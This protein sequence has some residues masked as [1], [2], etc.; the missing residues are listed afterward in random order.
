MGGSAAAERIGGEFLMANDYL[1]TDTELTSIADA[2]R[3]K[4][5]TSAALI[6]PVDFVTAI[7]AI[8]TGGGSVT[9]DQDGYIVLP[10][11]GSGGGGG[12]TGLVFE[13]GIYTP[14]ADEQTPT[15]TF[16][17]AHT[18]LPFFVGIF[19]MTETAVPSTGLIQWVLLNYN[20]LFNGTITY[21]STTLYGLKPFCT[22]IGSNMSAT[23]SQITSLTGNETAS[24]SYYLTT[25]G[26]TPNLTGTRY[27][28]ANRNYK[29]IAAWAP[30]T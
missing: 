9:Q 19:D 27:F 12:G 28:L 29:W 4:G 15:F 30:T 5:G 2:I 11:T 23:S 26:I 1:T 24:M 20:A 21:G 7:N 16:T 8:T 18:S 17:D 10:S 13:Q 22:S 3:T 25:T 14:T 6:F